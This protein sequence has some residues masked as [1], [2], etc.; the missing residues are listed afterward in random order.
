MRRVLGC[1]VLVGVSSV[2]GWSA[3]SVRASVVRADRVIVHCGVGSY[4]VPGNLGL[5]LSPSGGM[6]AVQRPAGVNRVHVFVISTGTGRVR[7]LRMTFVYGAT[8]LW[9]PNSRAF[10]ISRLDGSIASVDAAT[11]AMHTVMR[12]AAGTT[13][14]AAGWSPDGAHLVVTENTSQLPTVPDLRLLV[15]GVRDG[16]VHDLG[17]G[18]NGAYAPNGSTIAFFASGAIKL[19][20]VATGTEKAI[21][22]PLYP[23]VGLIAWSANGSE[24]AYSEGDVS[25]RPVVL[26]AAPVNGAHGR[27]MGTLGGFI[28]PIWAGRDLVWSPI[29]LAHTTGAIAVGNPTTGRINLIHPA[30]EPFIVGPISA[31]PGGTRI[32]YEV[33]DTTGRSLGLRSVAANGRADSPLVACRGR[34]HGDFVIGTRLNDVINV[35]NGSIDTVTCLGGTDTVI[36]DRRDHVSRNCEHVR[37]A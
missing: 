4:P 19:L 7:Q 33:A 14:T 21:A 11:G 24:V 30:G 16:H 3:A 15:V 32:A 17:D 37:L 22:P 6:L 5:E 20:T 26:T 10:A 28:R 18:S 25:G 2:A 1:L 31:L 9:A 12:P 35:R 27:V 36:A 13:I 34:G 8:P 23:L 29:N